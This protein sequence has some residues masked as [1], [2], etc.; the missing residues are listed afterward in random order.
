M[1]ETALLDYREGNTTEP[2]KPTSEEVITLVRPLTS[3][4]LRRFMEYADIALKTVYSCG[5]VSVIKEDKEFD[6]NDLEYL[7]GD[8][9]ISAE[10]ITIDT[11]KGIS[12]CELKLLRNSH[13]R[14]AIFS[15]N[16]LRDD[17]SAFL[18]GEFE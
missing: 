8:I 13:W 7:T 6:F 16:G 4:E 18:N 12:G 15:A 3:D 2:D 14:D 11:K 17:L 5:K 9:K 1:S 10:P